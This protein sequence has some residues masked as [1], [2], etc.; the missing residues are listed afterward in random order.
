MQAIDKFGRLDILVNNAGLG[1]PCRIT[2]ANAVEV[3]DQVF[4]LDVRSVYY[5]THLVLPYLEKS[6]GCIVNI[7]S[8]AAVKPVSFILKLKRFYFAR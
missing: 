2:D 3:L 6:K 4:R 1:I 7:S 5:L 8:I